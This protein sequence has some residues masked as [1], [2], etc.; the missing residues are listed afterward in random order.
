MQ[1]ATVCNRLNFALYVDELKRSDIVVDRL[2]CEARA[3]AHRPNDSTSGYSENSQLRVNNDRTT[4]LP[5][6]SAVTSTGSDQPSSMAYSRSSSGVTATP[7]RTRWVSVS[8]ALGGKVWMLLNSP[9]TSASLIWLVKRLIISGN[10]L[11]TWCRLTKETRISP[12][13]AKKPDLIL[14]AEYS[15]WNEGQDWSGVYVLLPVEERDAG[16][17]LD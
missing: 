13:S 5:Y 7:T 2:V 12:S 1:F 17:D 8:P 10:T 9:D 4:R 3:M 15:R 16:I 6:S 14:Q 11:A